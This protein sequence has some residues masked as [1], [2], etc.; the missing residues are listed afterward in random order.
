LVA[1]AIVRRPEGAADWMIDER[2]ARWRDSAHNVVRGA[3]DQC[4]NSARFDHMG[5]ETDGLMAEGSIG[6]QQREIDARLL[7]VIDNG[8]R[9]LVFNLLLPAHT[10]H[11]RKVKR[12]R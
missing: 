7:Q 5:D 1:L 12:R 9:Q 8:G 10:A 11:E 6:N 3:D 2:R 4:R